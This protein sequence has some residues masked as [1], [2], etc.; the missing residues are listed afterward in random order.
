MSHVI[1]NVYK[2]AIRAREFML[3]FGSSASHIPI[4]WYYLNI[5][6]VFPES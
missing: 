6:V 1:W 2:N 3:C 4:L 5:A